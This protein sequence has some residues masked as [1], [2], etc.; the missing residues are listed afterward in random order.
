MPCR[1]R[2]VASM[3]TLGTFCPALAPFDTAMSRGPPS[4]AVTVVEIGRW[5]QFRILA[6]PVSEQIRHLL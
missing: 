5:L 3:P 2:T 4:P 6:D 1:F